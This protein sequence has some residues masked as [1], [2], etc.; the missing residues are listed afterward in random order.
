MFSRNQY[1]LFLSHSAMIDRD[2]RARPFQLDM[3]Y[4]RAWCTNFR[5]FRFSPMDSAYLASIKQK[6]HPM[7]NPSSKRNQYPSRGILTRAFGIP[8]FFGEARSLGRS[9]LPRPLVAHMAVLTDSS[10]MQLKA[11]FSRV[12]ASGIKRTRIMGA[13]R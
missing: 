1:C 2:S 7:H 3:P 13:A 11:V 12:D 8:W 9:I 10:D 5:F 4:R 6:R